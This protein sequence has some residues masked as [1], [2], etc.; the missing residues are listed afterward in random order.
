MSPPGRAK[1]AEPVPSDGQADQLT[2]YHTLSEQVSWY[3]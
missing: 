2:A 3:E 1:V